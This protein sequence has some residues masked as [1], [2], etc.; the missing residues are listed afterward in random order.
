MLFCVSLSSERVQIRRSRKLSRQAQKRRAVELTGHLCVVRRHCQRQSP[1]PNTCVLF[2][3]TSKSRMKG[4]LRDS[5]TLERWQEPRKI[6]SQGKSSRGEPKRKRDSSSCSLMCFCFESF[7]CALEH[8]MRC[9]D[10]GGAALCLARRRRRYSV[11]QK[12]NI[13]EI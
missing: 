9:L 3:K 2:N 8:M 1:V 10:K 12:G 6:N 7:F 5:C 11:T 13:S 4:K